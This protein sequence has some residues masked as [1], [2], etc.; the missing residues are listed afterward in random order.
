VPIYALHGT[1]PSGN[2]GL[3]GTGGCGVV[4]LRTNKSLAGGF[5]GWEHKHSVFLGPHELR[6]IL[7]PPLLYL[8]ED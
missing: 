6:A 5:G 7:F 2:H 4:G 1:L 3:A 8:L